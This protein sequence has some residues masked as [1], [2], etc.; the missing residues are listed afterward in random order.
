MWLGAL[1]L[2]AWFVRRPTGPDHVLAALLGLILVFAFGLAWRASP[3]L[4]FW[5]VAAVLAGAVA[6][7]THLRG[8]LARAWAPENPAYADVFEYCRTASVKT[9]AP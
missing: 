1:L 2:T 3:F 7:G 6:V 5:N 8:R 9:A 4:R